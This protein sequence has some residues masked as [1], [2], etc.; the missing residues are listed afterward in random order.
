MSK[1]LW[2]F[3][4]FSNSL[5]LFIHVPPWRHACQD[6]RQKGKASLVSV[7]PQKI[8]LQPDASM[9]PSK[10][11]A[12]PVPTHKQRNAESHMYMKLILTARLFIT[13]SRGKEIL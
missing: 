9:K 12:M 3:S 5:F 11:H 6:Y 2:T 4:E 10:H 13:K 7:S 1:L 8:K